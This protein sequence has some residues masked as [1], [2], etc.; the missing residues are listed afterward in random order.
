M[1]IAGEPSGD[2][3]ASELVVALR[4]LAPA[5]DLAPEFYAAGGPL[6]AAAGVPLLTD[7]TRHSVIGLWEAVRKYGEFR[8]LFHQLLDEAVRRRPTVV[9]GVDYGGFNLR[10]A[11][12]LRRRSQGT[13]WHPHLIQFVSPQVWASRAGRARVLEENHDLLLSILPFEPAWYARHAPHLAVE[14]VGH[15]LVD[16]HGPR[17]ESDFSA[18]HPPSLVLL[19]G[20]RPAELERHLPVLLRAL[21]QV[22]A[23]H[24][25]APRLVLPNES[26]AALARPLIVQLGLPAPPIEVGG[27]GEALAGASL[28]W[29]STGTVTLECAWYG[30]PTLAL[31]RTSWSTYQIGRRLIQVPYLAMPNLLAGKVVMPE[32]I[33]D[34][35][36]PE[37][38]TAATL[39]RLRRPEILAAER[40]AL[41]AVV[42]SLGA[43]GAAARA[44]D[45]ILRRVV[46]A[47]G[48]LPAARSR[49]TLA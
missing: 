29:A 12:A 24:P 16:R 2:Q 45:A 3:L 38:F 49:P 18:K 48:Q 4:E 23:A 46:N 13:D 35:A 47:G 27:L 8:R 42:D 30:V 26:L 36:T 34:A 32:F 33:Q 20:S 15:P 37:A 25:V 28:A 19:P 22:Q 6:L 39:E 14:F 10:F 21:A 7:L 44:A 31:Y 41:R 9:I 17:P 11:R 1:L 5:F 43:P 40:Q